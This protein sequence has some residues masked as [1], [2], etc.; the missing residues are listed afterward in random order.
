[1][2][3]GGSVMGDLC[4]ENVD[5]VASLATKNYLQLLFVV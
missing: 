2:Y 1:M 4:V 3:T 5:M